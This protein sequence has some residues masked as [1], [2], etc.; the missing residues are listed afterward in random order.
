VH[1][2][3]DE[4][5]Y[6][7]Q[8]DHGTH[9]NLEGLESASELSTTPPSLLHNLVELI[10]TQNEL[11]CRLVQGQQEIQQLLQQQQYQSSGCPIH[12]PQVADYQ[13]PNEETNEEKDIYSDSLLPSSQLPMKLTEVKAR[14]PKRSL[15]PIDL[16]GW[17]IT[18]TEFIPRRRHQTVKTSNNDTVFRV[19]PLS[20]IEEK[21]DQ[22]G[23]STPENSSVGMLVMLPLDN[24]QLRGPSDTNHCF[25]CGSACHFIRECPQARPQN[26]DQ[27]LSQINKDNRRMQKIERNRRRR[28]RKLQRN[29]LK[30]QMDLVGQEQ[31]N[32]THLTELP[33][34]APVRTG[35]FLTPN[36][37]AFSLAF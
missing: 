23:N 25:N 2:Q 35:I 32:F 17:K 12:Q 16:T 5:V 13:G 19:R 26:Q 34:S 36:R 11:L 9:L 18:C 30:R 1:P 10:A 3:T 8:M 21:I 7:L 28:E 15:D 14:N 29:E 31:T 24:N 20:P 37:L 22:E 4:E 33:A 27:G 6:T